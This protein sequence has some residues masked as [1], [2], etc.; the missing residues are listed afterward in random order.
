[1]WDPDTDDWRF[2]WPYNQDREFDLCD[3]SGDG[4]LDANEVEECFVNRC[5]ADCS[6]EAQIAARTDQW[7]ECMTNS[8]E[9]IFEQFDL[10]GDRTI[11][12]TEFYPIYDQSTDNVQ[13]DWSLSTTSVSYLWEAGVE[14]CI[15]TKTT[16]VGT[17]CQDERLDVAASKCC[18]AGFRSTT[19]IATL[20]AA[21]Q[22]ERV[23]EYIAANAADDRCKVSGARC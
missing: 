15:E 3:Q 11:G 18:N 17:D 13:I 19:P 8:P 9:I 4:E 10:N 14:Q 20:T 2:T 22:E 23:Y 16:C 7:C 21:C 1:M 12:R 6:T 5:L